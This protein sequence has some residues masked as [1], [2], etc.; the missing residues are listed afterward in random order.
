[1]HI[2]HRLFPND[3]D[4]DTVRTVFLKWQASIAIMHQ[5]SYH[6]EEHDLHS[7]VRSPFFSDE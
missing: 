6:T 1:M 7:F 3:D 5:G 2:L 4:M